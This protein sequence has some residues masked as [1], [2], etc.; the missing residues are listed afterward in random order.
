MRHRKVHN[1]QEQLEPYSSYIL[2]GEE[3]ELF[4]LNQIFGNNNPVEL[5]V[6]IGKGKFI[7]TKAVN[8]MDKNFIGMELRDQII[9]RAVTKA[10]EAKI[11]NI[12]FMI[13]DAM[14]NT[15]HLPD[16]S[17][18]TIYLNFSDPWPKGKHAKRRLTS[19]NFLGSYRR[20]LK[21]DGWI[22]FKSDNLELFQYTLNVLAEN[23]M[24]MKDIT[25]DLHSDSRFEDNVTTEYE[26]RF[27]LLGKKIMAVSFKFR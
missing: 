19:E 10:G 8:G 24:I 21:D 16:K 5:E 15:L 13:G 14:L 20:I 22:K 12:R 23:D 1:V 18:D 11:P 2:K 4:D 9:L 26:E 27:H 7:T 25:L 3:N 6:G 17:I